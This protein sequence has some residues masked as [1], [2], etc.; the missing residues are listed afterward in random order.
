MKIN[1]N[2]E[3]YKPKWRIDHEEQKHKQQTIPKVKS[4]VTQK[5]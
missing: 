4:Y 3:L 5:G 2:A 1:R